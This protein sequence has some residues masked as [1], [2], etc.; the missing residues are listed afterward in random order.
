MNKKT[1]VKV[2]GKEWTEATIEFR[3][4]CLSICGS[5]GEI[6]TPRHAKTLAIKYWQS[7]FE[8]QPEELQSMRERFPQFHGRRPL[9]GARFVVSV[10]GKYHGLDVHKEDEQGVWLLW[11][12]GQCV[13]E[14]KNAFPQLVPILPWH[15]KT[16]IPT[17]VLN[18][19]EAL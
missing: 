2:E 9:A 15:M 7:F 12:C 17:D 13:D 14:M 8:E 10:D 6:V 3:N 1:L 16:D 5:Y 4:G 18:Q 11:G 19:I